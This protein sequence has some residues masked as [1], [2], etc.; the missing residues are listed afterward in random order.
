[1]NYDMRGIYIYTFVDKTSGCPLLFG[2]CRNEMRREV[3]W[4]VWF[5]SSVLLAD[6]VAFRAPGTPS[7][8]ITSS[9]MVRRRRFK[10][11]P[12]LCSR[13][14]IHCALRRGSSPQAGATFV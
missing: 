7:K 5:L 14:E 11:S 12:F 4:R 6:C 3:F 9:I 8:R 10:M 1:M 2:W 13:G